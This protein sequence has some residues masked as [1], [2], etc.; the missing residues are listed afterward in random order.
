MIR[1]RLHHRAVRLTEVGGAGLTNELLQGK[2]AIVW[3]TA[4]WCAPCFISA[5]RVA[6]LDDA[7]GGD[8]FRSLVVFVDLQES[9]DDL[10]NWR[11]QYARDDWLVAFD[12]ATDG[13]T[14]AAGVQ[15]LD[16][17]FLLDRD[18]VIRDVNTKIADDAYL[19]RVRGLVERAP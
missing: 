9:E 10:L 8:A 6:E 4:S 3:F 16:T 5:R 7:L 12:T 11:R 1:K 14:Q 15:L 18:G 2:P 19:D 17:K 13:L